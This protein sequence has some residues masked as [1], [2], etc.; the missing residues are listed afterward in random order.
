M[1]GAQ[2]DSHKTHSMDDVLLTHREPFARVRDSN[3]WGTQWVLGGCEPR[4][5]WLP[6]SLY[7]LNTHDWS[8][9]LL[10]QDPLNG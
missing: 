9:D 3:L 2:I 8:T 6:E 7:G 10:S 5:S 1:T 4:V